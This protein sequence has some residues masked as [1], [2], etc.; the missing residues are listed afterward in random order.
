MATY[1]ELY[2]IAGDAALHERIQIALVIVADNIRTEAVD[3]PY[4][5]ERIRW[6]KEVIYTASSMAVPVAL[7]LVAQFKDSTVLQ[8]ESV[9][10]AQLLNAIENTLGILVEKNY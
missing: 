7:A 10:D 9:S 2:T 5:K 1:T 6:A 3:T 8:L 4:H